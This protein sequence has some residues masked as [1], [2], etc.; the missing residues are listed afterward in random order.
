MNWY[1]RVQLINGIISFFIGIFVLSR[2]FKNKVYYYYSIFCFF[3][4]LWGTGY[5]LWCLQTNYHLSLFWFKMLMFAATFIH[6]FYLHTALLIVNKIRKFKYL[7]FFAYLTSFAF[8][9]LFFT[10]YLI[11]NF[12]QHKYS[13]TYWPDA[14]PL[15]TTFLLI[16]VSI[17]YFVVYLFYREYKTAKDYR[18]KNQMK[19]LCVLTFFG[20]SGGFTNWFYW[21]N[22]PVPPFGNAFVTIYLILTTY[23]IIKHNLF[24][25]NL[26]I[27]KGLI[28]SILL[29]LISILYFSFVFIIETLFRG[30]VGYRATPWTLYMILIFA[31][32]FQPLRKR[33][34]DIVDKY[35]F[36]GTI[37]QIEQENILLREELQRSEKLKAVG[38]LAAG[39]AHEIKNPLTSIKTFTE[40]LPRK[41]RDKDFINKFQKIVGSEVE[42]INNIVKQLLNFAKPK[43]L[44]LKI[45]NI[46]SLI[47]ETLEFLSNE[48]IKHKIKIVKDYK[49]LHPMVKVDPVQIK[50]SILNLILNA[51]EA[52]EDTGGQL[53]VSLKNLE[54]SGAVKI[55][56]EDT[57][58]GINKKDFAH[59]FD[60]FYST[61]DTNTGLGLSI[62]HGIVQKH[63]GRIEVKSS[64]GK[65]T[66]F[67][68]FLPK[69]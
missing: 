67:S 10:P 62:V 68:I 11:T 28:Y 27:R 9:I 63:S 47:D 21:Y 29:S 51:I 45:C 37:D 2:D 4:S 22:I 69:T 64:F 19:Y 25:I 13:F 33:I 43:P 35:F 30:Y 5:F 1:G 24:D 7:L 12:D 26:F 18:R 17:A 40:Y 42:K 46:Q 38:T 58:C 61:K 57:G 41:Y 34:Q 6:T 16:G 8:A 65:G 48:F 52:M 39:M 3:L 50:Q 44:E 49:L 59:L 66:I 32:V 14:N 53:K 36:K 56:I 31:I 20:F 15:I 23:A 55:E 54:S 60:P